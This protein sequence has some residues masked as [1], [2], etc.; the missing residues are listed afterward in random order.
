MCTELEHV[1]FSMISGSR[2]FVPAPRHRPVCHM[3]ECHLPF[4][5]SRDSKCTFQMMWDYVVKYRIVCD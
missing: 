2:H 4:L 3:V 5:R 1:N